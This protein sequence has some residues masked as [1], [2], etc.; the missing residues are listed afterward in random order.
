MSSKNYTRQGFGGNYKRNGEVSP[1]KPPTTLFPQQ[2][3]GD[4]NKQQ[5]NNNN[6]DSVKQYA[7]YDP[8]PWSNS[9]SRY[10]GAK[11]FSVAPEQPQPVSILNNQPE[12]QSEESPSV[13]S[14]VKNFEGHRSKVQGQPM[15]TKDPVTR[16]KVSELRESLVRKSNEN[17]HEARDTDSTNATPVK[18]VDLTPPS[19]TPPPIPTENESSTSPPQKT[20]KSEKTPPATKDKP[21][22]KT[23]KLR[24]S[25]QQ[26]V[27]TVESSAILRVNTS[28]D[29]P[30]LPRKK[31]VGQTPPSPAPVEE[32]VIT[33]RK[34]E[35]KPVDINLVEKLESPKSSPKTTPKSS[36]TSPKAAL[37]TSHVRQ[38]SMEEIACEKQAAL[39]V[40]QLGEEERQLIEVILPPPE[41][42]TATDY[43]NGL[44]DTDV[45]TSRKPSIQ[46]KHE[47]KAA[48]NDK[49]G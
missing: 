16:T 5:Q 18:V 12:E 6:M 11:P 15:G 27:E 8:P 44:F 25:P 49:E 23:P 30:P 47:K 13:R 21:R 24:K 38:K 40:R 4:N 7:K 10:F 17:L 1:I 14:V 39:V 20:E 22:R 33:P 35:P 48:Q 2:Q 37:T 3:E 29:A 45:D 43:I 34:A 31:S 9:R 36:K 26:V 19:Y 32:P 42:K 46:V 41:H 28:D